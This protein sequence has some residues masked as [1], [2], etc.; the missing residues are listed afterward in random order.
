MAGS[1]W[2]VKQE[3]EAYSW[4][5]FVSDGRTAWTGVRSYPARLHLRAMQRDDLALFYH[6]V[7]EKRVMGVARILRTAY[8]D[9]TAEGEGDWSS[10]DLEPVMALAEPVTLNQLKADP[11][12]RGMA[13]IRQSRLSV[14]P[15][16]S[17]EFERVLE[18][19]RTRL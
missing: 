14:S 16:T 8:P 4:A 1:R 10:V 17:A 11:A 19:A 6:S 9:P 15:L 18:L 5:T 13:W 12:T 3:P 7:T 2:L